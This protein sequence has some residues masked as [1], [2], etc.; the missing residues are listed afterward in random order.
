MVLGRE[1]ASLEEADGFLRSTWRRLDRGLSRSRYT[2]ENDSKDIAC[3]F[4]RGNMLLFSPVL[5][6]RRFNSIVVAE[7]N[8]DMVV[9][10]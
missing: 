1:L 10:L 9:P 3:K 5:I 8:R 2:G 6:S 7:W 4:G